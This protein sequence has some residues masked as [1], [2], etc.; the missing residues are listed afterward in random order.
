MNR[1]RHKLE[2]DLGMEHHLLD[3][4]LRL[5]KA[6]PIGA[7]AHQAGTIRFGTEPGTSTLDP[8]CKAHEPDDLSVADTSSSRAS[9]R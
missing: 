6:M 9:E 8:N 1:L 5:H 7:T 3:H 4:S 2:S